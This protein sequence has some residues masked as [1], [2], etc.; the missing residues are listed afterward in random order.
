[1]PPEAEQSRSHSRVA[2]RP[3][4]VD[5]HTPLRVH[6][7]LARL[8]LP[9]IVFP[10]QQLQQL[11]EFCLTDVASIRASVTLFLAHN[12]SN[13]TSDVHSSDTSII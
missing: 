11:V 10:K 4:R 9:A 8:V 5:L 6:E 3:G 13:S 12:L 7:C 1:M 2:L